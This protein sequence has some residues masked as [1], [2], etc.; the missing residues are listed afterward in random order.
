ME[1]HRTPGDILKKYSQEPLKLAPKEGLALING[2]Q[3]ISAYAVKV[4]EELQNCLD[5]A[6]IIAAMNLE[7]MLGSQ[8]PFLPELHALRPYEGANMWPTG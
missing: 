8:Q 5:H 3:F 1:N 2:T 6:D 4:A 7:A